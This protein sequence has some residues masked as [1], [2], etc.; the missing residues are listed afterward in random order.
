WDIHAQRVL[1]RFKVT[2]L[3]SLVLALFPRR[4]GKTIAVA[5]FIAVMLVVVNGITISTFST[6]K[7]A[8][9]SMMEEIIRILAGH[10]SIMQRIVKQNEEKL[11]IAA[12]SASRRFARDVSTFNSYP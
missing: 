11:Q 12:S 1:A 3:K 4:F 10:E 9:G 5:C 8:S 6:G 7:R 2:T